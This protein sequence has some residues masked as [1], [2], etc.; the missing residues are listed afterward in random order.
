MTELIIAASFAIIISAGC[1]L[2]ESVLYS[3]PTRHIETMVQAG[4]STG[5]LF[6][7]MR[8]DIDRP[9]AAILSLNTIANTAGAAVAGSAA[10]AVFGYQ[11]LGFFSAFFTVAVLVFAEILPKTAGVVYCRSL[12]PKVAYPLR[13]L[14]WFMTPAIW[15]SGLITRLFTGDK[16]EEAITAEEIR[17]MA[18]LSLQTGGIKLYQ[19]QAIENI[20][21]L[22]N[23]Q[24]KDVMTPRT[25]IFSLSEHLTVEEASK[26]ATNWEHSRFPV[27]DQDMEDVVG[28]VFTKELFMALTEGKKDMHLTELMRPVHFVVET[29]RLNTVLMEYLELRQHLFVVLD[30]YG[31]LAGLSSLEDILEEILGREIVDESDEVADKRE[32]ARSRRERLVGKS[33]IVN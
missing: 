25:V 31:G 20:L 6:K 29:A 12:V 16:S 19:E 11:W 28:V 3:V 7:K 24:V 10:S 17:V 21:T 22:Q 4:K 9:I 2:F 15:L 27:Y 14:V 33:K 23:K 1:S 26:V 8:R 13:G 32:L 5:K 30:E 18:R